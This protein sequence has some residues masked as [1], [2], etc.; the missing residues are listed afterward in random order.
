[1]GG[2]AMVHMKIDSR[3]GRQFCLMG[4]VVVLPSHLVLEMEEAVEAMMS[5]WSSFLGSTAFRMLYREVN[6]D[7]LL[8]FHWSVSDSVQ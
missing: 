3:S 5:D 1:L 8:C 7:H 2:Y 6:P 4:G